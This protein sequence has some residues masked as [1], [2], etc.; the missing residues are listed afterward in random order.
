VPI[1]HASKL[2][3]R[4]GGVTQR[5][6]IELPGREGGVAQAHGRA[7][8]L[9]NLPIVRRAYAGDNQPER[10]RAGIIAAKSKGLA[11]FNATGKPRSRGPVLSPLDAEMAAMRLRSSAFTVA[12]L[13]R[14]P[15]R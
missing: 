5:L 10:V 1:H 15:S 12:T 11:S 3:E 2:A 6:A 7:K 8:G 13:A 14:H 9:D 4:V